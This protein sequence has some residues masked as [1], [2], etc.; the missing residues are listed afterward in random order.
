MGQ[1]NVKNL[2]EVEMDDL[3][4]KKPKVVKEEKKKKK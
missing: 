3:E 2:P 4:V 1:N